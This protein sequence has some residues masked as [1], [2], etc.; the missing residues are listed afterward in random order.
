M[1]LKFFKIH[2]N[3]LIKYKM[4]CQYCQTVLKRQFNE[5][6]DGLKP[7]LYHQFVKEIATGAYRSN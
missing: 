1:I 3:I 6:S 5:I 2:L 4:E 7:D